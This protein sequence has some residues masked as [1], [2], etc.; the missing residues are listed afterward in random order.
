MG[1]EEVRP[2]HVVGS[3]VQACHHRGLGGALSE[4]RC[5]GLLEVGGLANVTVNEGNARLAQAR[6]VGS[7]ASVQVV[8]RHELPVGVAAGQLKRQVRAPRS[9]RRP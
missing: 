5:H 9:R 2:D 1:P 7:T 8:E 3:G 4:R 6:D